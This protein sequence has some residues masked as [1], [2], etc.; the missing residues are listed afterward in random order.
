M[1]AAFWFDGTGAYHFSNSANPTGKP[2]F[3]QAASNSSNLSLVLIW[4]H[5][6][7]AENARPTHAG[8]NGNEVLS[9]VVFTCASE[10]ALSRLSNLRRCLAL[11]R[12]RQNPPRLHRRTLIPKRTRV[13]WALPLRMSSNSIAAPSVPMLTDTKPKIAR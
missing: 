12:E 1:F 3:R 5:R 8:T 4:C 9:L 7:H 10:R 13:A 11:A 2:S 6:N